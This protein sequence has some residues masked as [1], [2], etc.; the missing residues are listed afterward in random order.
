MKS[1]RDRAI[2]IVHEVLGGGR[3]MSR[4][5]FLHLADDD[6]DMGKNIAKQIDIVERGLIRDRADCDKARSPS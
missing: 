2:D 5:A 3:A 6:G 4:A 1:A